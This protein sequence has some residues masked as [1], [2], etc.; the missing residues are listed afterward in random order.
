M[1][2]ANWRDVIINTAAKNSNL[3]ESVFHSLPQNSIRTIVDFNVRRRTAAQN[4]SL[5]SGT[6]GHIV[7]YPLYFL[8]REILSNT[9]IAKEV[10]IHNIYI[11]I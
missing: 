5:L 8:D 10:H 11:Y 3:Y 9:G 6:R 7:L 4:E 2:A 1:S